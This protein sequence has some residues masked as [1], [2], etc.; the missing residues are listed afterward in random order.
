MFMRNQSRFVG[1]ISRPKLHGVGT[2]AGALLPDGRVAHMTQDGAE[3]VSLATFAQNQPVR[4]EKT[5]APEL[6]SQLQQRAFLSAGRTKPYDL[7][8]K[9]CEHYAS[10]LLGEE[11]KSPQVVAAV[12]AC[13]VGALAFAG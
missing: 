5:A 9:N 1:A 10:W 13:I 11:P 7:L 6:H 12:I 2:H 3:I 8:T 4:F